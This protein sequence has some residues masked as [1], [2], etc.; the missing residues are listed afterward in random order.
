ME[1]ALLLWIFTLAQ[2]SVRLTY[3]DKEPARQ[4]KTREACSTAGTM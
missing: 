4:N 3:P 2:I 1:K